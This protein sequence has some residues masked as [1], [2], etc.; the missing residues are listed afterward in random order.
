[1]RKSQERYRASSPT[2][3]RIVH[4]IGGL[5]KSPTSAQSPVIVLD[6]GY[7]T[8]Q[9][10]ARVP[11]LNGVLLGYRGRQAILVRLAMFWT[12]F[13]RCHS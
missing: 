3:D 10:L 9:A 5:F 11:E 8:G 2:Q 12:G 6:A 1:M 4:T 7:G 13:K